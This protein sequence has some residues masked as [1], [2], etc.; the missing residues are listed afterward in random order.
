MS[1]RNRTSAVFGR[2]E[3]SARL[4]QKTVRR[5]TDKVTRTCRKRSSVRCLND[6]RRYVVRFDGPFRRDVTVHRDIGVRHRARPVRQ[7]HLLEG[8]A[9]GAQ[10]D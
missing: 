5:R 8:D 10:L 6:S 4:H 1:S 7:V 2:L 3:W 9:T